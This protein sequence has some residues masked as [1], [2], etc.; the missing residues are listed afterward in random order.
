MKICVAQTKSLKGNVQKNIKNHLQSIKNAIELN[1]DLI[2]FPELSIT[3]YEPSLAKE[4]ATK[5]KDSIFNPF[6]ELSD[7]NNIIIGIGMLINYCVS[8]CSF[9]SSSRVM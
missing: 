8:P 6:K 2:I 4:L 1:S 5:I 3:N 9:G 7:E